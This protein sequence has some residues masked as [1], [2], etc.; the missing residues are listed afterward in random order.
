MPAARSRVEP[1]QVTT[2]ALP[3]RDVELVQRGRMILDVCA[4]DLQAAESLLGPFHET[5]WYFRSALEDARRSW[6]RLRADLG[7]L[8]L[9]AALRRPPATLLTLK[10]GQP[11]RSVVLVPIA[12]QTYH[13]AG[14]RGTPIAPVQ[15]RLERLPP[16]EDGPYFLCR[17][18][19]GATQCDC[20]EWVFQIAD[21]ES[22]QT[23]C[24]HLSALRALGWI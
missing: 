8:A 17:L 14:A 24:K 5:T 12:G 23:L 2:L 10:R 4:A 19:D 22:P 13:V 18:K 16:H 11:P 9:E 6:D 3:T 21:T 1:S 20:A 7:T 15:W